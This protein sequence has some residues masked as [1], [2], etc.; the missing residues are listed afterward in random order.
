MQLIFVMNFI[1]FFQTVSVTVF[2]LEFDHY[3]HFKRL[4]HCSAIDGNCHDYCVSGS[5]GDVGCGS[6]F[7]DGTGSVSDCM[8]GSCSHCRY[9]CWVWVDSGDN[10]E[11][12][13]YVH[14]KTN[15]R[16]LELDGA[17]KRDKENNNDNNNTIFKHLVLKIET[18]YL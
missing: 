5:C 11:L 4:F 3:V 15:Q 1:S 17:N 10:M 13:V 2:L 8:T 7:C 18:I 6:G 14:C 9:H 16:L 12:G